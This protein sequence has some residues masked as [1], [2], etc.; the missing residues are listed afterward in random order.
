MRAL[1]VALLAAALGGSAAQ[2]APNFSSSSKSVDKAS[3]LPGDTVTYTIRV[4]STGDA[5]TIT[6]QDALPAGVTYVAGSTTAS[7]PG[8]PININVPDAG[9]QSGLA[10]G[11]TLPVAL[12]FTVPV[13]GITINEVDFTLRATVNANASGKSATPRR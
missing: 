8:L 1:I 5:A 10:G 3:A 11:F 13:I 6:V 9:G 7:A 4:L 2:A 12:P